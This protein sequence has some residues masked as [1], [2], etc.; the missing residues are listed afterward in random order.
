MIVDFERDSVHVSRTV[1][2]ED[3]LGLCDTRFG[4]LLVVCPGSLAIEGIRLDG[5][6]IEKTVQDLSPSSHL[7]SE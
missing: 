4:V 5:I 1:G 3:F 6:D 7:R 2:G